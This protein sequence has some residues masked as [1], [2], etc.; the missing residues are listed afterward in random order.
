[1]GILRFILALSVLIGHSDHSVGIPALH[2]TVAVR[3]FY[4]IS[5][6]YMALVL[7]TRYRWKPY[8]TFIRSRYLRLL[9]AYVTILLATI[10]YGYVTYNI[11]DTVEWP[12]QGWART[13]TD[14][15]PSTIAILS[16]SN[17]F[18][19]GQDIL[20][21]FN[22]D[23]SGNLTLK[24]IGNHPEELF[25]GYMIIPQAWTLGI[26]LLFYL[27]APFIVLRSPGFIFSIILASLSLQ[28]IA[29][30]M[31][32]IPMELFGYNFYPFELVYFSLGIL[33]FKLYSSIALKTIQILPMTLI[34]LAIFSLYLFPSLG[35]P[36]WARYILLALSIPFIFSLSN[37][38][39]IDRFI[40]ELSYPMYISHILVF[41]AITQ[42]TTW[43][44][45]SSGTAITIAISFLIYYFVDRVFDRWREN[46]T[47]YFPLRYPSIKTFFACCF[48]VFFALAIPVTLRYAAQ[49]R[50]LKQSIPI[51]EYNLLEDHPVKLVSVGLEPV[52]SE[53]LE[54]FRW[55]LGEKTELIFS[56]PHPIN[57]ILTFEYSPLPQKQ[58]VSIYFNGIFLETISSVQ[59]GTV[60]RQYTLPGRKENNVI[61]FVYQD[62][63]GRQAVYVSGDSRPLAASFTK[64]GMAFVEPN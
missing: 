28:F 60:Y 42:F 57:I 22:F 9:P 43:G 18:I 34:T 37:K 31:A 35:A 58:A 8:Y 48:I 46:L 49:S 21:Y 32:G 20:S 62:W 50:H 40:G 36:T 16:F 38:N 3:S 45:E 44:T 52:E 10:I 19:L 26:E 17:I 41:Y 63:N 39:R 59:L 6:F 2:T 12:F 61:R 13:I 54:R 5:G 1:M 53:M 4:I 51:S 27:S 15:S 55:G 47:E 29:L 25:G 23:N 30:P 24:L 7:S 14:L 64:L 11:R 33:S 56:L